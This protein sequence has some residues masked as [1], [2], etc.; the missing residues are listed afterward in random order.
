MKE[1]YRIFHYNNGFS[2]RVDSIANGIETNDGSIFLT[3]ADG[4]KT[5]VKPGWVATTF[6]E[7]VAPAPVQRD[8]DVNQT[9]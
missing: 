7:V 8:A 5:F 3:S 4:E 2:L 1:Q 6:K 9:R